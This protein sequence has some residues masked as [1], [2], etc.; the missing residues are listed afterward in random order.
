MSSAQFMAASIS[1]DR[2]GAQLDSLGFPISGSPTL[3]DMKK[4]T[5]FGERLFAARTHAK[6]TQAQLSKAAG[7]SQGT[8]GEL[9]WVGDGSSATVRL[10]MACGVRP[11]W[12]AEDEGDMLDPR[13]WPFSLVTE[14]EI[15]SLDDHQRGIVEGA[16]LSALE[17][18]HS[19]N[20]QD[21]QRFR[22]AHVVPQRRAQKRRLG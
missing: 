20:Q 14:E 19:P 1:A 16:L 2:L 13:A 4:R 9:E 5:P 10:A 15:L 21:L 22:D 7:I 12:L 8:L 6:L 3:R 18:I 17:R 11:E